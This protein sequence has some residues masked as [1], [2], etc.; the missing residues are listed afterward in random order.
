M[1]EKLREFDPSDPFD[2]MTERF[3]REVL[4]LA[5]DAGRTT[6]YREM[7]PQQQMESFIAGVLTGL[8]SVAFGSIHPSGRDSAMSYIAECLP[9]ARFFAEAVE[10]SPPRGTGE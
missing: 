4:T 6:I 5:L 1:E 8:V 7:T 2:A 9:M 10:A 3:R